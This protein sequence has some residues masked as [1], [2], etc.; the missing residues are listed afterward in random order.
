MDDAGWERTFDYLH[1]TL[2][3]HVTLQHPDLSLKLVCQDT[4]DFH[5]NLYLRGIVVHNEAGREREVR[6]FFAH[7]FHIRGHEVGDSAYY[8][9]ERRAVFHYKDKRWFMINVAKE[10][11]GGWATGVDGWAVGLKEVGG[12]EGTWRDAEDGE[13][14]GNA[15]AQGSVDSTV[16]LHLGVPAHFADAFGEHDLAA[17]YRRAADE[18]RAGAEAHMWR[19]DR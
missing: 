19:P 17:T 2:V 18:I 5:E 13:L 14:S 10:D 8:E 7:D 9:S 11:P 12:R 3:T 4:V 1:D 6:L 15:V 16:A